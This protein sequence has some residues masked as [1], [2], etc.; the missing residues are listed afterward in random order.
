MDSCDKFIKWNL[1]VSVDLP[2]DI[3]VDKFY[4]IRQDDHIRNESGRLVSKDIIK[5]PITLREYV[6]DKYEIFLGSIVFSNENRY[7]VVDFKYQGVD[8]MMNIFNK[9]YGIFAMCKK[10]LS[11]RITYSIKIDNIITLDKVRKDIIDDILD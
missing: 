5:Y 6:T 7:N 11:D 10:D 8:S 4:Y 2:P 9:S 3:I 1:D